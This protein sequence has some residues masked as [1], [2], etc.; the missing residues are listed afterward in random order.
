MPS[1][2]ANRRLLLVDDEPG[3]RATLPL[4]LQRHG[5]AVTA[6][7]V[8]EALRLIETQAFDVLVCD[9][10]V[11][12]SGDGYSVVAA[13]RQI[14]RRCVVIVL[15]GYPDLDTVLDSI[16]HGID[17]Y[18]IKPAGADALAA[19]VAEKLAARRP[20][21]CILSVSYDL[22]L[23]RTRN[24]LLEREGYEVVSTSTLQESLKRCREGGFDLFILGHSIPHADKQKL[25][26]EFRRQCEG[27][28]I[29]LRRSAGDQAV[30]DADYAIEPDPEPLLKLIAQI[31]RK[32]SQRATD[33]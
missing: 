3:I 14:D 27:A 16:H 20:K 23:L 25:V 18:L 1:E 30:D 10:N 28:V 26:K 22:P 12:A 4:A 19:A 6:A 29:S 21:T 9:L 5:Y 31:T 7:T 17:E 8:P 24:M 2:T 11:D 33:A 32:K 13:L 15:T